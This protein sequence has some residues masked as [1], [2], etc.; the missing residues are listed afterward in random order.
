MNKQSILYGLIL[1]AGIF[2]SCKRPSE[3]GF[4]SDR[5]D[6][7]EDTILVA[8]GVVQES[9]IPEIDGSSRP[10]EFKILQARYRGPNGG[11]M[12]S[13][14]LL[15]PQ[16]VRTW[17]QAFDR[18][19]HTTN[20]QIFSIINDTLLA[21]VIMNPNNGQL[22]F[23]T[24]TQY[25]TESDLY[26][27]DV[28]VKNKRGTRVVNDFALIKLAPI[29]PFEV[30]TNVNRVRIFYLT[31]DKSKK[32]QLYAY[33]PEDLPK[34]QR[35]LVA[36]TAPYVKLERISNDPTPGIKVELTYKDSKGKIVNPQ[37]IQGWPATG[38]GTIAGTYQNWY[39]N[40]TD[41]TYTSNAVTFEFPL[42]P[43]PYYSANWPYPSVNHS[44]AYHETKNPIPMAGVKLDTAALINDPANVTGAANIN[45]FRQ[46][47]EAGKGFISLYNTFAIRFNQGGTWRVTVTFPGVELP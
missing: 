45:N 16:Q 13:E 25:L 26:F 6:T 34:Y 10:L 38:A 23:Q 14:Q 7:K 11:T 35:D 43:W 30:T 36:G 8:R 42:T 29:I 37:E 21:P 32:I 44:L 47:Y 17:K 40:S 41:T 19:K 2:S 28:E 20:E 5:I 39:W 31:E 46:S 15:K 22:L 3:I 27:L 24:S 33:N 9:Q 4:I 12:T 1:A 18:T